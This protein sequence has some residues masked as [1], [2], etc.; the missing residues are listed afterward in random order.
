V[1]R[2]PFLSDGSLGEPELYAEGLTLA[3][4]L[5][6]DRAGNLLVVGFGMLWV[7]NRAGEVEVLSEDPLL[8]WPANLAFG[9]GPGFSN[10]DVY[11]ANF[12]QMFGNGTDVVRFR[13]SNPGAPLASAVRSQGRCSQ[14][15]ILPKRAPLG[16]GRIRCASAITRRLPRR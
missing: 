1:V 12:G 14:A 6:F 13:Y 9:Q 15:G 8:D 3:D 2:L 11:L 7:V 10:R 4:G 16:G 5:A